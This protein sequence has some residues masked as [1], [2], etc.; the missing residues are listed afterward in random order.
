MFVAMVF[1]NILDIIGV[2]YLLMVTYKWA[3]GYGW[4]RAFW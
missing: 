2:L 3:S 4:R 1:N